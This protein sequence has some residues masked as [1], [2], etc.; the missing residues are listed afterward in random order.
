MGYIWK[1]WNKL[2]LP[3]Q[4]AEPIFVAEIHEHFKNITKNDQASLGVSWNSQ[5]K[6]AM[7]LRL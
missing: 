6:F 5:S 2:T 3:E 7:N 1:A 4:D